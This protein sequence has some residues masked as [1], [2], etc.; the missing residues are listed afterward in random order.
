FEDGRAPT[1]DHCFVEREPD[2]CAV[3]GPKALDTNELTRQGTADAAPCP[4]RLALAEDDPEY[5]R[6]IDIDVHRRPRSSRSSSSESTF[7]PAGAKRFVRTSRKGRR[8]G[9]IVGAEAVVAGTSRTMARSRSVTSTSAPR[10]TARR[11]ADRLF[12]S[13]AI[14]TLFMATLG[15]IRTIPSTQGWTR[16]PSAGGAVQRRLA[17]RSGGAVAA[18]LH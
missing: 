11:C 14:R 7:H 13:S 9:T 3:D 12:F 16:R 8:A 15:Q 2:T 18:R 10:S 6:R 17:P 1:G 5:D 4:E